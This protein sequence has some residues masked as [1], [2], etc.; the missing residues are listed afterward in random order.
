[1]ATTGYFDGAKTSRGWYARLEWSYTQGTS[2]TITLTLKV[3]NGTAPS[4]NNFT[5]SAYY[6]SLIHI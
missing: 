1:M 3:Y 2:T 4:Y 5:N 6:L